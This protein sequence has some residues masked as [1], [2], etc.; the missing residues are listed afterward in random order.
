MLVNT[1]D[2]V[3]MYA[4]AGNP[5]MRWLA[6]SSDGCQISYYSFGTFFDFGATHGV[7]VYNTAVGAR[8]PSASV[9][10][11]EFE[12]LAETARSRVPTSEQVRMYQRIGSVK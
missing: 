4:G 6:G 9:I 11:A 12:A 7:E 2:V 5:L 10:G 1:R 3:A 8:R